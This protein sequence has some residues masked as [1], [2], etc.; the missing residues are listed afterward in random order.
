MQGID[1]RTPFA[2]R[3]EKDRQVFAEEDH[4]GNVLWALR[5]DEE[6]L[7]VANPNNPRGLPE[8]AYFDV[9]SDPGETDPYTDADAEARLEEM[10][11]LQRLAAEGKA[12]AGEETEMT[13][14][15][16][17]RLRVIGYVEDCSH[18]K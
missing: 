2:S 8:R 10:A 17:E 9:A 3:L 11:R 1:L 18:V 5:T 15:D 12:V 7:I 13:R 4:E 16:C 14:E 6:K